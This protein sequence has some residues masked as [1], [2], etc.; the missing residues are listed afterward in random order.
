MASDSQD[1]WRTLW[2]TLL[3]MAI[4][5][6]IH[7][8]E[9]LTV[10]PIPQKPGEISIVRRTARVLAMVHELHKAGYQRIRIFPHLAPSGGYWSCAITFNDNI[11][12]DG[13][14]ILNDYNPRHV[15]H[16][17]T[18]QDNQYFDWVGSEN[19]SAR[20]LAERFLKE[21]PEIAE[22]GQGRDWM[23]A[24]WL[25]EVLGRAE[26]GQMQDVLYLRAD[27]EIDPQEQRNWQPPPPFRHPLGW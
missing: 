25:T 10:R 16:Y 19:D 9:S 4:E 18:G 8:P 21:Y 3:G 24:G 15:A 23:Y 27:F 20:E 12:D 17:T 13:F 2:Q 5:W 6:Y 22:R 26:G 11:A 14:N 1:R 7:I